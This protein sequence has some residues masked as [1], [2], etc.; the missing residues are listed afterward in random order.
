LRI[1]AGKLFRLRGATA[2]SRNGLSHANKVRCAAMAEEL[3]WSVLGHLYSIRG[4]SSG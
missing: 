1:H 3:F 2:P 4:A